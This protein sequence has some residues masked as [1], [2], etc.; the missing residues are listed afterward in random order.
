MFL[1]LIFLR[2]YLEQFSHR[3]I[4]WSFWGLYL[5]VPLE[6]GL[7][8]VY[9]LFSSVLKRKPTFRNFFKLG[10][11]FSFIFHIFFIGLTV[12]QFYRF[13][14]SKGGL[15]SYIIGVLLTNWIAYRFTIRKDI[16]V[17]SI[18]ELNINNKTTPPNQA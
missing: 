12:S 2:S 14:L 4:F 6:F 13:M 3:F 7:I 11:C 5:Y 15:I 18:E 8:V 1:D 9:A 17:E 16:T 10:F